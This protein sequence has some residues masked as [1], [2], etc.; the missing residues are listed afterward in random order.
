MEG[1]RLAKV[2]ISKGVFDDREE[3]GEDSPPRSIADE[4]TDGDDETQ[5]DTGQPVSE[6]ESKE[7]ALPSQEDEK[8]YRRQAQVVEFG[9]SVAKAK[10]ACHPESGNTDKTPSSGER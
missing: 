9:T 7:A 1:H 2:R 4:V 8:R 6:A 10:D 5:P 3:S